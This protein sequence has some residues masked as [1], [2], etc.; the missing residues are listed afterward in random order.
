MKIQIDTNTKVIRLLESANF[1]KFVKFAKKL[2]GEEY[3]KF[4]LEIVANIQYIPWY[5]PIYIPYTQPYIQPYYDYTIP[6]NGTITTPNWTHMTTTI[7][8]D[9]STFTSADNL[10]DGEYLVVEPT[11]WD[12]GEEVHIYNFDIQELEESTKN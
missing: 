1:A 3:D 11:T 6:L 8:S 9:G 7:N 5:N 4:T 12:L 2:L 10:K